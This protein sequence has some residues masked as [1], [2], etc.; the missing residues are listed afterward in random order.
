M[1]TLYAPLLG[2]GVSLLAGCAPRAVPQD[3]G[4]SPASVTAPEA[5]ARS[6][7]RSLEEEPPLPGAPNEGW[8]GLCPAREPHGAHDHHMHDHDHQGHTA[9]GPAHHDTR[10]EQKP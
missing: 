8:H 6:V 9:P 1:K 2:I 5:E 7:I 10:A 4:P 3:T